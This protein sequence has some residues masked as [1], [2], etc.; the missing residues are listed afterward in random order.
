MAEQSADTPQTQPASKADELADRGRSLYRE[1]DLE[2]A[3]TYLH[4]AYGLHKD[5]GNQSGVAEAA[6]GYTRV[7]LAITTTSYQNSRR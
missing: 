3:L 2:E 1:G 7:P 4:Q 5:E 6:N